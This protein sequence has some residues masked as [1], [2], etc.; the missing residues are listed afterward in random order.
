[1]ADIVD[2]YNSKFDR[3][4]NIR[5]NNFFNN[6]KE[7]SALN[8]K[9][10]KSISNIDF[11]N[12]EN[13]TK[14][15]SAEE[16][17]RNAIAY[18]STEYPYDGDT[19]KKI[20]WVNSLSELEYHLVKNEFPKTVGCMSLSSSQYINV[21]S[22]VQQA[23]NNEK[24]TFSDKNF[25]TTNTLLDFQDGLTFESWIKFDESSDKTNILTV[26]AI[27]G[28]ETQ[29]STVE[30]FTIEKSVKEDFTSKLLIKN[31]FYTGE[32]NVELENYKWHHYAIT[33]KSGSAQLYV[34][35]V[36]RDSINDLGIQALI[37]DYIFVPLGLMLVP[38]YNKT[39]L[40][41]N[42][43]KQSVFKIGGGD[44]ITVDECRIWNG[45]RSTE[46]I[47][48]YWFSSVDGNDIS[49]PENSKLLLY[50]KFN[51]GWDKQYRFVCLDNSGRKNNGEIINF[52]LECPQEYS[53]IDDF[54]SEVQ[55]TP[56]VFSLFS[57]RMNSFTEAVTKTP[58]TN[59]ISPGEV[60][61]ISYGGIEYS[62]NVKNF[63]V[64][65]I[66]IASSYDETNFHSLYNKFPSWILEQEEE[67]EQK[68]LKQLLQIVAYYFDDLYLKI[69]EIA[70]YKDINY[71][72]D[73]DKIYPFYDK[74][75]SS[76]GFDLTDL[77]SEL[78]DL[79][80]IAS[81]TETH[82]FSNDVS[83][84]K[85]AIYKNIYN[86]LSYML[87]SK[88]TERAIKSFLRTYGVN[89]NLVKINLYADGGTY[90]AVINTEETIVKKK[91]LKLTGDG[92]ISLSQ[93][94]QALPYFTLETSFMLSPNLIQNN[95]T[96][97]IFGIKD[98]GGREFYVTLE[99][100][101]D[102]K[103][104]FVLNNFNGF[105][106]QKKSC[107]ISNYNIY[108]GSVWN[109]CLRKKPE[110]DTL[111]GAPSNYISTIEL[112]GVNT[113]THITQEFSCSLQYLGFDDI[114][115][116]IG[117]KKDSNENTVFQANSK[118]LYC[119]FWDDYLDN[120]TVISH[121]KD[122]LNYGPA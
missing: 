94:V 104:T 120:R 119:N 53:S 25:Y 61:D 79:E 114:T 67:S 83:K 113:N 62:E 55:P 48:R 90:D 81:R 22:H 43:N 20:E 18:I 59:K 10:Q 112:Y 70:N 102:N 36:L 9:Q 106:Q 31:S 77:F 52:S 41:E 47:G 92:S 35:G 51:E 95:T 1:M 111:Q 71:E 65:K 60:P 85:N 29:Y 42:Y 76:T 87:K 56:M 115:Y 122:I 39:P 38:L 110:I 16:K 14:F 15:G 64:D 72:T 26:Y 57:L 24:N 82:I 21:F 66:K 69:K 101:S 105:V 45:V 121:N 30:L 34:D 75:L 91:I 32:F 17:Y 80:K 23:A 84:V 44:K 117:A 99:K 4:K 2:L 68:H 108:D 33:I 3:E 11:S 73:L 107:T 27:T 50:Y 58:Q 103:N 49:D 13:F 8:K 93:P 40:E 88:G 74:I 28:S 37:E 19:A 6:E 118:F 96:S 100:S 97:S 98:E 109:L 46:N 86:N 116:Y 5:N 78:T 89:E 12:P 63:Y 7:I 54:F